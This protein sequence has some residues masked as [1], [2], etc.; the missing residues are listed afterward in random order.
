MF[1]WFMDPLTKG[2]YPRS[3]RLL[4]GD[5]LPKFSMEESRMVNGSFD[6]VGFNYYTTYYARA[7]PPR[8]KITR[9]SV[10]TDSRVNQTAVRNGV[11]IGPK[12]A[13]DWLY[14]Y[15]MGIRDL[16]L[17]TKHK[18]DNPLIYITENGVDEPN[19]EKLSLEE[20]LKDEMRIKYHHDHLAFLQLAIKEGVNVKGYFA[21][22][23]L[24][25]FEWQSGY[26][27]RFGIN[28]VDFKDGLKRYPKLSAHWFK[29]FL[30]R[31]D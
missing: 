1:G 19:N 20:A 29:K 31:K 30:Q 6:F 5:R 12:A 8:L 13:S 11:S 17:Y 23:L 7:Y 25:D 27:L 18:Y 4:V 9:P 16:L 24:D 28:Y 22:T 2:D 21:W 26:T 15:P 10:S 14:V 3:M